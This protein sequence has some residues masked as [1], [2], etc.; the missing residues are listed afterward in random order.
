M[1]ASKFGFFQTSAYIFVIYSSSKH[2]HSLIIVLMPC[3]DR[4]G[5]CETFDDRKFNFTI[6]VALQ[7]P[8]E[9]FY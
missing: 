3:E 8:S 2:V 6:V 7:K 1:S 4:V 5:R 9:G